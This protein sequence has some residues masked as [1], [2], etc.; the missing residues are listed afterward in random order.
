MQNFIDDLRQA[1]KALAKA[2][3]FALLALLTLGSGLAFAIYCCAIFLGSARGDIPFPDAHRLLPLEATRDGSRTQARSIHYLDY[4]A[5]AAGVKSFEGLQ[6][7]TISTVTL[8][9]AQHRPQN[10]RAAQ[11][12][13]AVWPW[14]GQRAMLGRLPQASDEQPGAAPVVV[15]GAGVWQ[16][17]FGSDPKIVGRLIKLNGVD[18]E[19]VGVAP[20]DLRFPMNQQVWTPFE[21]PAG[22]ARALGYSM[23][24]PQHVMA[25]GKLRPDATPA[26]AQQEL[27]LVAQQLATSFPKSNGRVGVLAL[28]YSAWGF[29]DGDGIYL[30]LA[31]AVGLLL[32]LVCINTGNLLLARANERRQEVAVRAAL[33]APRARLI[34]QVLGEA[35]LLSLAAT[36]I[37]M[38]FSAW[39]LEITQQQITLTAGEQIPFWLHFRLS[40]QA[41]AYGLAIGLLVTLGVGGLPAWRA[42]RVDVAAVLRDGQRGA[43]GRAAGYFSRGLVWVQIT[44]S[45]LLLLV[46]CGQSYEMQQ[47][48]D[49]QSGARRDN[50]LTAQL[51]PRFRVYNDP[52]ARGQ[53]WA[54]LETA[55]REQAGGLG[56]GLTTSLPGGGMRSW[57]D[58]QPEGMVVQD[59]RYPVVGSYSIN[60]GYLKTMEV[61]LLAGREF[62][63]NDRADSLKVAIVNRNFAEQHWPGQDPLGKRFVISPDDKKTGQN[64]IT[65]VG[66]TAHMTHGVSNQEGRS[67]P[68]VYLPLSQSVPDQVDIALVG[69][70]DNAASR[71]LLLRAVAKADPALA[72]ERVYSADERERVASSG[73]D[74]QAAL[75]LVLGLMTLLLAVTGIY[76]V[77]SRAVA[78]RTQEIG[79]RRAVGASDSA[80]LWLLLRQG[81]WQIGLSLPLGLFL[82]WSILAQIGDMGPE[83][84]IGAAL[85]ALMISTVVMLATW[86]PARRA[87]A[88]IPNAA[89]RYE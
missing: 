52:V 44:L 39:A 58:V 76:G 4:Q 85:V 56:V 21:P 75:T 51:V 36:L 77:A 35:L 13:A 86:L 70:P 62:D 37:G 33:G 73:A 46:S 14:L 74:I 54:R 20:A 79:V 60:A 48:L 40:P 84:L 81:L 2:P 61:K 82:G 55:L 41:A 5:Y 28:N 83:L 68:N 25:L 16:S 42:S 57:D 7:L 59:G 87:I 18:T 65:V 1:F 43:S 19:I 66:V 23:G 38:F 10:F 26:Q 49:A 72:L 27:N 80:V 45:S 3:G 6:A 50:V 67:F 88:L 12:P 11:V 9:D 24:T 69:A 71:E 17:F 63:A 32:S 89:L 31:I 29:S 47:R 64:W 53:L 22:A 30:A 78:L 15:I 8:S 34:Q